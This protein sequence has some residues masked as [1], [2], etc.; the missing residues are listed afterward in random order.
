MRILVTGATGLIGCHCVAALI[1]A[2]HTVRVFVRDPAKLDRVFA[3]FGFARASV[4]VALGGVGERDAIRA[5][6]A[7]CQ[8]LLH[9]AGLFS[10]DRQDEALL[11][12]TNVD[13]TR[14]V[15]EAAGEM[16]LERTVYV[17][18]M[19]ALFPPSGDRMTAD[20]EVA[21]PSSMYAATKA[22]AERVARDLQSRMPLTIVYP[23][24]VQ[25]PDDPTFSIGPQL[26]ANALTAGEVLVTEGGLATTDVRDLAAV[27]AG[28]F[29]GK[30]NAAR[31]MAPSFYVRHD[32]YHALLESLSGR[33]LKAQRMPG[34]LLRILGRFGD[35]AQ[36][37]G[38]SVQLTYEAAEVLTRSVPVDDREA[39]RILGRERVGDEESFRDLIAWMVAAGHIDAAAAGQAAPGAPDAEA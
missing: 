30:S 10:P 24:A 39:C 35:V 19:L 31:V 32:R 16:G 36:R 26:V 8:G 3:P 18:S 9:C 27:V 5:A 4:E 20:D 38:R 15:L 25:G 33:T 21:K 37:F 12:E 22:G 14:N 23:S 2:G 1:A 6:L 17:S 11:V 13:G 7:G 29:D 28:I 34:W